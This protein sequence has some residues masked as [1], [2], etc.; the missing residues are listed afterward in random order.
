MKTIKLIFAFLLFPLLISISYSQNK[1][2]LKN[3]SKDS[4]D[5]I[6]EP[7]L[8]ILADKQP[9]YI[10]DGDLSKY[11]YSNI[12]WPMDGQ[13]DVIG[14][15]I[16]SFVINKNGNIVNIKV[17]NSLH[18]LC[19]NEVIRVFENMSQWEPG[20]KDSKLIDTKM[21]FQYDFKIISSISKADS[22][23]KLDRPIFYL[24]VDK[25]PKF[26]YE[27]GLNNYIFSQLKGPYNYDLYPCTI[28]VSFEI[29][30]IGKV[31][32]VRIRKG[33]N[34][35]FDEE[36]KKAFENMP[37]WEPGEK[38]SK[39]VNV[40]LLYPLEIKLSEKFIKGNE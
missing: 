28:L 33:M 35:F 15:V 23:S 18:D 8:Y 12:K 1:D 30:K 36:V 37:N 7:V 3:S 24:F 13:M 19:N 6:E 21:L 22:I 10:Y 27:D 38:N 25:L 40:K 2:L 31:K 14:T 29:N 11:I 9:K 26:N 5:K 16:I 17:E 32:N 34:Q 20:E 4:L 39:P